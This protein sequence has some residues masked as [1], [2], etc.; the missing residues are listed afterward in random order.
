MDLLEALKTAVAGLRAQ[1]GRMRVISENLANADTTAQRP[2]ENPYRRR[3][4]S[5]E[6]H[7]DPNTGARSVRLGRLRLDTAPFRMRFE[8]GHPAADDKGYVKLP[9]VNSIIETSDFRE[10][11]RAYEAGLNMIEGVRRI[12]TRTIDIIRR[13]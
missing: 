8:P 11:N 1:S 4:A 5:F 9:N 3:V 13:G 7:L 2:G 12:Q 6:S 10:A